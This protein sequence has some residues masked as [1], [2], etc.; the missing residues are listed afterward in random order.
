MMRFLYL[1]FITALLVPATLNAQNIIWS[2]SGPSI[3]HPAP[4][5]PINYPTLI[6]S[7]TDAA[8]NTY[9]A[10]EFTGSTTIST[11]QLHS[12]GGKDIFLVKY[13]PEGEVVWAKNYGTSSDQSIAAI[14]FKNSQLY[15]AGKDGDKAFVSQLDPMGTV[16]W[17][18]HPITGKALLKDL[19]L[20][21][22]NHILLLGEFEGTINIKGTTLSS[23]RKDMFLAKLSPT[24]GLVWAIQSDTQAEG[25]YPETY[26]TG[27]ATALDLETDATG[28]I[29]ISGYANNTVLFG[30]NVYSYYKDSFYIAK[31]N[32][33]GSF[34]WFG[35]AANPG[36][37][38]PSLHD[39]EVDGAGNVY[40]AGQFQEHF[41][42]SSGQN[43]LVFVGPDSPEQ[44]F[45][46]KLT[47]AGAPAWHMQPTTVSNEP[48][49]PCNPYCYNVRS[50][51]NS[52]A[53]DQNNNVYLSGT[54]HNDI[55]AITIQGNTRVN[56]HLIK[57]PGKGIADV[58]VMKVNSQ[59]G[60]SWVT[61]AGG[62]GFDNSEQIS[63]DQNN[64]IYWAGYFTNSATFGNNTL[65]GSG[66]TAFLAKVGTAAAAASVFTLIDA[67]KNSE[68]RSIANNDVIY[69][70][71]LNANRLNIKA[72]FGMS[73][74][75]SV[76]FTYD[77][78]RKVEN[79]APYA[80]GGDRD[81]N[82][83]NWTLTLGTHTLTARAYSSPNGRGTLLAESTITFEVKA[84]EVNPI[85]IEEISFLRS[86]RGTYASYQVKATSADNS[87]LRYSATGLPAGLSI[88]P[89]TGLIS[90]FIP[91][92]PGAPE[93]VSTMPTVQVSNANGDVAVQTF[94]W[95]LYQYPNTIV[96]F[97]LVNAETN[98]DI[99]PLENGSVIDYAQ[100]STRRINIRAL[101]S[102]GTIELVTFYLN[103]RVERDER[104]AP[105]A[106][107]GDRNGNY[108]AWTP[109]AGTYTVEAA[110]LYRDGSALR[111]A[112]R[113]SVT[114]TVTGGSSLASATIAD[115]TLTPEGDTEVSAYPNPFSDRMTVSFTASQ[116]ETM[117]GELFNIKGERIQVVFDAATE[118]G[119]TY[120]YEVSGAHLPEGV[121]FIKMQSAS[122][123]AV[124]RLILSR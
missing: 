104:E 24:M 9:V 36:S 68:I 16:A 90:G 66:P 87:A 39:I 26:E 89:A 20:D 45:L 17:W 57:S 76:V 116:D 109:A 58:Y 65:T 72:D 50:S 38:V 47:P 27:Y 111:A 80:L 48:N 56:D 115:E 107:K 35:S 52:L 103:G 112:P 5:N 118:K 25:E 67:A 54:L 114:F 81:G 78:A 21:K 122:R 98:T 105:Y 88:N 82:Y 55:Y 42:Y 70:A 12:S 119:K 53:I 44:F 7:A 22:N 8:G 123:T 18:Q 84:S 40:L 33:A 19:E 94:H 79:V 117:R 124:K 28:N 31:L 10:G 86:S 93:L 51:G 121:Y 62:P 77:G 92:E 3:Q 102:T 15:L 75:G 95:Q 37:G 46:L 59:G 13:S 30:D 34:Q 73:G 41:S 96:Q 106:L 110:P 69:L 120:A 32:S 11:H 29:Y 63:L 23:V 2:K 83:H 60:I 97:V 100:I 74:I 14:Q 61:T 1:F 49:A 6:K 113:A 71:G 4:H 64:N 85:T 108:H 43:N 101:T 91:L 99:M